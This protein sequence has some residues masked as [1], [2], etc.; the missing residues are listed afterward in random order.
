[1]LT[2]M[3]TEYRESG[4]TVRDVVD[5]AAGGNSAVCRYFAK[6]GHRISVAAITKWKNEN[7]I[8][9]SRVPLMSALTGIPGHLLR[10][11]MFPR[12]VA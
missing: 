8:P 11:D 12:E 7:R 2:P 3:S 5:K 1:M 4:L 10:P 9:A 6:H